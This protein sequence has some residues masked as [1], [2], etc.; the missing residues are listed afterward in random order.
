M[1]TYAGGPIFVPVE[2][3]VGSLVQTIQI[4]ITEEF[5]LLIPEEV[6]WVAANK[7]MSQTMPRFWMDQ[8]RSVYMAILEESKRTV[9]LEPEDV[10][11]IPVEGEIE[12]DGPPAW[13]AQ[14]TNSGSG[15][16]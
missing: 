10:G 1:P 12:V 2:V 3:S 15:K 14:V 4:P 11:V 6:V 8:Q 13:V 9:L 5:R 7:Y 16:T